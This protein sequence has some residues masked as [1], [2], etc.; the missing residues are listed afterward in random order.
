[1][2]HIYF[3]LAML[4]CSIMSF[5]GCAEH[6]Q[7]TE[8]HAHHIPLTA[9][10]G[11]TE[12]YAEIH[13]I[14]VGEECPLIAHF[15]KL[16]TFKPVRNGQV[17]LVVDING[18]KQT[19]TAN[20]P[21]KPGIYIFRF[22][23]QNEGKV[24]LLLTLHE[25]HE[26]TAFRFDSLMAFKDD[27]KAH[28]DAE[29]RLPEN[30]NT[31]VFPKEMSWGV[32]FSTAQVSHKNMGEIIR[33]TAQVLPGQGDEITISSK[34]SGI[35]NLSSVSLT[36]GSPIKAGQAICQIDASATPHTNLK[37][38]YAQAEA[39]YKHAKSEYERSKNLMADRLVTS[40]QLSEARGKFESAEA[41]YKNLQ[42][43][44]SAGKQLVSSPCNGY[45]QELLATNG[46]YVTE[47]QPL[48][49]IT[50]SRAIRLQAYVAARYFNA[51]RNISGATICKRNPRETYSLD[52][53]GGKVISYGK[54][55]SFDNPLLPVIFEINN[56]GNFVSGSLVDLYIK[57]SSPHE[58]LAIPTE[59][60]MEDMGHYFVFVQITPEMFER[61]QVVIGCTD[62][63][64]TEIT[65]GL[66]G[67]ERI[68]NRGAILVKLQQSSGTIDAHA[69]HNH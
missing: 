29:N 38:E 6:H 69:G 60:V 36:P 64:D 54:Q 27:E 2:R 37:V 21:E 15:T 8:Y 65:E 30:A 57:T 17:T 26:K 24:T 63:Q 12:L 50:Q 61:R 18:N 62:G 48:L 11:Q 59:A 46:A 34:V 51:L 32:D 3:A 10:N 9:Y 39:E 56:R 44:F 68:V 58:V 55:V 43:N 47:G 23:P 20:S 31:V 53:L 66:L 49:I 4:A 41:V 7:E 45:I 5:S 16:D 33:T 28:E 14:V 13:P 35:V 22:T 19:L 40:T 1:M 42:K 67:N 25:E 52:S